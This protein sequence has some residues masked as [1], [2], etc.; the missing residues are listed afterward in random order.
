[1]ATLL[2]VPREDWSAHLVRG[3]VWAMGTASA[4]GSRHPAAMPSRGLQRLRLTL[5]EALLGARANTSGARA[6]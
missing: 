6:R 2:G 5:L 1:V 3:L 4:L